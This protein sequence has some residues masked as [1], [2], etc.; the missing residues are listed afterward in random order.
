M[1]LSVR[2]L[3]VSYGKRLILDNISF[4]AN[5]GEL[6]TVVG[7]NGAGKSTLFYCLLGIKHPDSG[8]IYVK[9]KNI[10]SYGVTEYAKEI[11][12]VPQSHAPTFNYSVFD[13]VLMGTTA[14][15]SGFSAPKEKQAEAVMSSLDRVGISDLSHRGYL[16][17]SGG[18][19]QLVLI[20]R[21][22]AQNAKTLIMDE[23]TANLDYGNQ[24]RVL[25]CVKSLAKSGYTVILSSHNPEHAFLFA[26]RVL[27]LKDGTVCAV[28]TPDDVLSEEL[29]FTLYGVPVSLRKTDTGTLIE[30]VIPA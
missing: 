19:R 26:D 18:E 25:S 1:S 7:Q 20:A 22:L 2:N 15:V 4:D 14:Q 12:Y 9:D 30:P 27:A 3:S 29:L 11:A 23:P 6:L 5:P 17:I 24:L 8:D 10:N 16:R 28:G 13:M 21:A